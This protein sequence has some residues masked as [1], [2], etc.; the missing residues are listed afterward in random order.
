MLFG[1][2]L[3][4]LFT[5]SKGWLLPS[6]PLGEARRWGSIGAFRSLR[7]KSTA[8]IFLA[9]ELKGERS[10]RLSDAAITNPS[11]LTP[12]YDVGATAREEPAVS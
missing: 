11:I 7:S 2:N 4:Y 12:P 6:P 1:R 10:Q 9:R 8:Q 3:I 5:F